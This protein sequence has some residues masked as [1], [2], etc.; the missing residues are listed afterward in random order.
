MRFKAFVCYGDPGLN[1]YNAINIYLYVVL[2]YIL[3]F[4]GYLFYYLYIILHFFMLGHIFT[5]LMTLDFLE[6]AMAGKKRAV[7]LEVGHP[8]GGDEGGITNQ[9]MQ[10]NFLRAHSLG[11]PCG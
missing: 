5:P 1:V 4:I 6:S 10:N 8:W 2:H 3:L 11:D 9:I 7:H